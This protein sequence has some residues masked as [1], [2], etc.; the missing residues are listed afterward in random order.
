MLWLESLLWTFVKPWFVMLWNEGVDVFIFWKGNWKIMQTIDEWFTF[1]I[2]IKKSEFRILFISL[3]V[4]VLLGAWLFG[5]LC[6]IFGWFW[7]ILWAHF[8]VV[9]YSL[10]RFCSL[11]LNDCELKLIYFLSFSSAF[12]VF[13]WC[14]KLYFA[15]KV[16]IWF[17]FLMIFISEISGIGFLHK[18]CCYL[19]CHWL[20]G[21]HFPCYI[22]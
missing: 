22:I 1:A 18:H 12:R 2:E 4:R 8:L 15:K 11:V 19:C 6:S 21:S 9:Y 3:L 17:D 14:I 5:I 10:F 13:F 20:C 16:G 7:S